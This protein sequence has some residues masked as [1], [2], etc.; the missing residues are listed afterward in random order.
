MRLAVINKEKCRPDLCAHECKKY[1]PIEKKETD[2]C[3][4]IGEKAV[5]NED[6]CIGCK[7]C[8]KVCPFGAIDII[9]LPEVYEK[10]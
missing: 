9:N 6:T 3:I 2:S 8:V 1:C 7:I 4:V 10:N 5:I